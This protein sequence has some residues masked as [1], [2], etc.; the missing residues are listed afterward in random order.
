M[1]FTAIPRSVLK[2]EP[3]PELVPKPSMPRGER[4]RQLIELL[5]RWETV[6]A[7]VDLADHDDFFDRLYELIVGCKPRV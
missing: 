1:T 3:K 6:R 2:L 7:S 5:D 4:A